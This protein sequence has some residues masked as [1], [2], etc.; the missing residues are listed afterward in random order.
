MIRIALCGLALAG[1][2]SAARAGELD[3]EAG[4]AKVTPAQ[5]AP[6]PAAATEL[7]RESPADAHRW[8]GGWGYGGGWGGG[9]G[10]GGFYR[11]GFALSINTYPAYYG[12]NYPAWGNVSYVGFGGFGTSGFGGPG[13]CW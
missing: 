8:R 1:F 7:D 4:A 5:A 3:R 11:P 6:A 12:W 13:W 9:W 2:G 10:Y